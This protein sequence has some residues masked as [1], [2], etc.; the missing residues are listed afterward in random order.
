MIHP[1]FFRQRQASLLN[2]GALGMTPFST[3]SWSVKPSV[4]QDRFEKSLPSVRFGAKVPATE[5]EM[6]AWLSQ[7]PDPQ[8]KLLG[9]GGNYF[10]DERIEQQQFMTVGGKNST[11]CT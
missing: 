2:S 10:P 9:M 8:D 3:A 4:S 1:F 11:T 5:A 7:L 6:T